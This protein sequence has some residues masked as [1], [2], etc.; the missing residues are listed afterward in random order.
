[1]KIV[2][3]LGIA[4]LLILGFYSLKNKEKTNNPNSIHFSQ[5][6]WNETLTEAEKQNKLIFLDVYATWCGPCKKMKKTTFNNEEVGSFFNKNFINIAIDGETTEGQQIIKK[7]GLRGYPSL[8]FVNGDGSLKAIKTG[9]QNTN[10]L[11]SYGKNIMK[12]KN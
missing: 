7:Y 10:D 12:Q 3:T 11:L 4:L 9:F 5:R 2:I 1:M 6:S 8:L